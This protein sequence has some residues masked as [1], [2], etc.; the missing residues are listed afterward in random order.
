MSNYDYDLIVIGGGSGG[1]R[2]ARLAGSLG[3]KVALIESSKI[4]GT[5]VQRGCVPKKL[6]VFASQY[7]K[8]FKESQGF[9][10]SKQSHSF[11]WQHLVK[12]KVKE[13]TFLESI[14]S[15]NI[16]KANVEIIKGYGSFVDQHTISIDNQRTITGENIVI[17]VGGTP[18]VP[19]MEGKEYTITSDEVFDLP[20]LPQ[21]PIIIGGGYIGF[22]FAGIFNAFGSDVTVINIDDKLMPNMDVQAKDFA[23]EAIKN[24]GV[25][26]LTN[27]TVKSVEK[28]GDMLKV[29]L[30]NDE[31]LE[32][33]CVLVSTGRIPNVANLELEKAGIKTK[34]RG[35]II[36]DDY[37]KTNVDN[38]YAVGDVTG[39][40]QL[41][42]VAIREAVALVETLF[43]NNPSVVDYENI[44]TAIFSQPSSAKCGLT[45]EE[46][47]EKF[48][49]DNIECFT[50]TFTPLKGRITQDLTKVFVKGIVDKQSNKV[51]GVHYVGDGAGEI[52]QGLGIAIKAGATKDDFNNTIGIHPTSAEEFTTLL[53]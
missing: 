51:I 39:R 8:F 20:K 36:V 35:T 25:N 41:T 21:K 43:H 19:P 24:Y 13:L 46:A 40:L 22:E 3:K 17:A 7:N 42:P 4:G 50:S 6:Y 27:T 52:M 48:C 23:I 45:E 30:N 37:S 32:S 18:F 34:G 44:P 29:T 12:S 10:W 26:I 28:N 2:T 1:V 31:I 53:K 11:D 5:C 15:S 38:I 16:E 49:K 33:D 14:Y 47:N 9:G